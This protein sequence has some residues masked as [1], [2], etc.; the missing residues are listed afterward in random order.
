[1]Q[2]PIGLSLTQGLALDRHVVFTNPPTVNGTFQNW[3]YGPAFTVAPSA[4]NKPSVT[5][6]EKIGGDNETAYLKGWHVH[7]PADHTVQGDRSKAEL[8]FVYGNAS[9]A[10][11]AVF[12][13]RIDPGNTESDF[14]GQLP[15]M[16]SFRDK[17]HDVPNTHLNLNFALDEVNRFSEFWTYR[18]SLTSPPCTEGIRFFVAR[19]IL[20]VSNEQ[21]QAILEVSTYSA[22][23]EQ[24]V[25]LHAINA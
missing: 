8:H 11:R 2:S 5:F 3:G 16:I 9:G 20:F 19:N 24:E 13:M 6:Q 21:M 7:S 14:F 10:N 18:G 17:S 1:M 23:A 12:A 4:E 15:P 25:W 22:R